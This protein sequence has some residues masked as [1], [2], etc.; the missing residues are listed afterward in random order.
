M[1]V[2]K[3]KGADAVDGG[4]LGDAKLI[5]EPPHFGVFVGDPF[6]NGHSIAMAPLDRETA[7]ELVDEAPGLAR[8]ASPQAREA[9][10]ATLVALAR[11]AV[12]H[13]EVVAVDVNPLILSAGG[14][15]AVDALVIVDRGGGG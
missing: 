1:L 5:V 3:F 11:L 6:V 8:V 9:L 4:A 15:T 13:P 12:D 2:E 7:L 10:A 14:A